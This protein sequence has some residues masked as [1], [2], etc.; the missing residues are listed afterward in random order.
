MYFFFNLFF[1]NIASYFTAQLLASSTGYAPVALVS[2]RRRKKLLFI[3]ILYFY[4]LKMIK[5]N[6]ISI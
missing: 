5:K 2:L 4:L 1:V 3:L 6:S